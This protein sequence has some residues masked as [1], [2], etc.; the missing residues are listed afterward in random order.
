MEASE[1]QPDP[2]PPSETGLSEGQDEAEA[3]LAEQEIEASD[4]E[5]TTDELEAFPD[6][7]DEPA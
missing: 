5:L 2:M 1:Q 7:D 4:S 6:P 3:A